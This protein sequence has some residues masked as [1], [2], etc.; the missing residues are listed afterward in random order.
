[1]CKYGLFWNTFIDPVANPVCFTDKNKGPNPGLRSTC[2]VIWTL[3][4]QLLFISSTP[5]E[6]KL[7]SH[8]PWI[9]IQFFVGKFS[10]TW[11]LFSISRIESAIKLLRHKI[12]DTSWHS[13][14]HVVDVKNSCKTFPEL[15]QTQK[16]T[17]LVPVLTPTENEKYLLM[18]II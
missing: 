18:L 16:F 11:T 6:K 4:S 1:M 3:F 17:S 7:W 15:T 14:V 2:W 9:M 8:F 13:Q 12:V 5:L 10:C